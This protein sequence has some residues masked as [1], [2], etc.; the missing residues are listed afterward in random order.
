MLSS[1][2]QP[3]VPVKRKR[4]RP[5][6]SS[7]LNNNA[8]NVTTTMGTM[9]YSVE[10]PIKKRRGRP[11]KHLKHLYAKASMPS[12]GS[13]KSPTILKDAK[14]SKSYLD[15][16][17]YKKPSMFSDNRSPIHGESARYSSQSSAQLSPVTVVGHG[18][19]PVKRKRGRPRKV[20]VQ[21]SPK[22]DDDSQDD[23]NEA[24]STNSWNDEYHDDTN[25]RKKRNM[26]YTLQDCDSSSDSMEWS[27]DAFRR[28]SIFSDHEI[29]PENYLFIDTE[30]DKETATILAALKKTRLN[31]PLQTSPTDS[32]KKFTYEFKEPA[33]HFRAPKRYVEDYSSDDSSDDFEFTRGVFERYASSAM[34]AKYAY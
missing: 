1:V 2:A 27:P 30:K 9:K 16:A 18:D 4:G 5:P 32:T 7:Y 26:D 21:E 3:A 33:E 23:F 28:T 25:S 20:V 11:P 34:K 8:N 24:A 31:Y 13:P 29:F 10:M 15:I 14:P 6:K 12:A 22:R 19:Q 17:G